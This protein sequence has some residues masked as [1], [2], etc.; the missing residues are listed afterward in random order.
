MSA[1]MNGAINVSI[2]DGWVPEFA[3]DK[4]N[5]FVIPP[6]DPIL[7]DYAQDD[8]DAA[9]LY[10]LLEREV[11]PMYYDKPLQWMAVL[12]NSMRDIIPC[13]DSNRM[14]TEYYQKLY[15]LPFNAD[16]VI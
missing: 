10:D 3:K 16:G 12:K 2:P 1:A 7:P 6:T 14:V 5:S 8:A 4:V 11:I 13:F 15:G 9:S